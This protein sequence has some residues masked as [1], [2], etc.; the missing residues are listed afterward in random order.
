MT[1]IDIRRARLDDTAAISALF[2]ARV[3]IWQR[4]NARGQVDDLPYDRLTIYERWLHGGS[5]AAPWMSI[6]IGALLLNQLLLG[7][8]LPLVAV[9]DD[10]VCGYAEAYPGNEPAPIGAHLHLAH[11]ITD[12]S[13][14]A[15]AERL[16]DGIFDHA[17]RAKVARVTVARSA[18]DDEAGA[19]FD[20]RGFSPLITA[21]R[22]SLPSQAGQGVY[23]TT[24][25]PD[26]D[27]AQIDGWYMSIGRTESA[28]QHWE[29]IW[30]RQF[31]GIE[32]IAARKTHRLRFSGGG[33]EALICCQAQLYDPRSIEVFCWSP[34]PLASQLLTGIRDWAQRQG[35][36]SLALTVLET[37]RTL[38]GDAEQIPYRQ[39]THAAPV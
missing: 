25:H 39:E 14:P 18:Y 21:V 33:Q 9:V 12:G 1:D 5:N 32:E 15:L 27:P 6:E 34:K 13:D 20:R 29:A 31:N 37:S 35:Y 4:L 26:P 3:P 23:K 17:R 10:R 7:A 16:L 28:R 11:L 24:D 30:P 38:L 19:I 2:R 22:Y 36:K 8:G